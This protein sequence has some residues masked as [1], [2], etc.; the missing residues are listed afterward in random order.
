M[1][2]TTLWFGIV[3]FFWTGFFVLEGFDFGVGVLA[4]L[5]GRTDRERAAYLETIGPHWDGNEVWLVVAIGAMF[6]A[7]P[8]WY[9][10]LLS[11]SYLPVVLALVGLIVRGVALEWRGKRDDALW[12][13]RCDL[14]IALGSAMV[15]LVL[16][17]VLVGGATGNFAYA[18][19]GGVVLLALCL[20]HGAAF[21]ALRTSGELRA[22]VPHTSRDALFFA[23]TSVVIAGTIVA[24]FVTSFPRAMPGL[25]Y[26]DAAA[27]PYALK[28][29]T[30]IGAACVPLVLA[31]QGWS[32]WVFRRRVATS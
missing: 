22:R 7:F 4:R 18:I 21:L 15:P 19:A 13:R 28:I 20:V 31:Y 2:L 30:W 9:A 29:L 25:A 1:D 16:G 6:A 3:V 23:A 8:A 32:Y 10:E 26:G 11:T 12:R 14:G 24:L 5:L 27:S 17:A